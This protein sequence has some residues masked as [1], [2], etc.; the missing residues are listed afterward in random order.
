MEGCIDMTCTIIALVVTCVGTPMPKSTPAQ[1]VAILKQASPPYVAPVVLLA[2]P[3]WSR[4]LATGP[5]LG[6]WDFPE[7]RAPRR[8]DGT[9]LSDPVAQYGISSVYQVYVPVLYSR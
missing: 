7:P 3:Q 5:T 2:G 4:T 9:L 6:P 1:A 8:L